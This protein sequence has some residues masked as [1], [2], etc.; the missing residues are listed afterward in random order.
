MVIAPYIVKKGSKR[1]FAK[2]VI[3]MASQEF[4]VEQSGAVMARPEH[5]TRPSSVT[6]DNYG[7]IRDLQ[8]DLGLGLTVIAGRNGCGNSDILDA[9][10]LYFNGVDIRDTRRLDE[11]P[12]P[13][14]NSQV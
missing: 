14:D 8:V 5:G 13:P 9:L 10:H 7:Y 4:G 3:W 11:S 2:R 12:P 6:I 1:K